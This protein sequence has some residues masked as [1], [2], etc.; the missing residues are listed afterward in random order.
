MSRPR[1]YTDED[2]YA[3]VAVEL[4]KAG[5]DAVS[6]PEAARLGE[7]DSAQLLWATQEN[8]VLVTFNVHDFARLHHEWMHRGLHHSGLVVSQQRPIG[9]VVR[10]VLRIAS[11]LSSDEMTDRLEYLSQW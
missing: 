4:R 10:R 3:A 8:R 6:A 1:F 2:I 5:I 7:T 9:D 11:S